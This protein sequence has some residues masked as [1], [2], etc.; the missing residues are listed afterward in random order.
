MSRK[1]STIPASVPVIAAVTAAT[2]HSWLSVVR[3]LVKQEKVLVP[4]DALLCAVAVAAFFLW[5]FRSGRQV[6]LRKGHLLT[7]LLMIACLISCI[8]ACFVWKKNML[9]PNRIYL[10]TPLRPF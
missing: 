2:F 8:V 6:R 7:G 5:F 9:Y 4:I 3:L 10:W 1:D